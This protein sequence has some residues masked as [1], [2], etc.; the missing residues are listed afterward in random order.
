MILTYF[1]FQKIAKPKKMYRIQE[2]TIINA[3]KEKVFAKI[4]NFADYESWNTWIKKA[5]GTAEKEGIV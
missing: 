4:T 5:E 2:T 3:P 1:P